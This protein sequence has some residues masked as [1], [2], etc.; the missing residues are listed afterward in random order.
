MRFSHFNNVPLVS[1]GPHYNDLIQFFVQN[2]NME[3]SWLPQ[4]AVKM[5][6]LGEARTPGVKNTP[7]NKKMHKDCVK[8]CIGRQQGSN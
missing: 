4:G 5:P 2:L 3:V 8:K 1:A 6:F 7:T